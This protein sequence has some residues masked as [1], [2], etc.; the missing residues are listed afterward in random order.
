MIK[1]KKKMIWMKFVQKYYYFK[2]N[3]CAH[4][5]WAQVRDNIFDIQF[6]A[7]NFS[8]RG[9]TVINN[10]AKKSIEKNKIQTRIVICVEF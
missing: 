2:K 10:F 7:Y 4:H 1:K 3:I 8:S 9:F 6:S 5:P